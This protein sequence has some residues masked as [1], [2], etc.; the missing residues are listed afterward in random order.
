MQGKWKLAYE[1]LNELNFE[2]HCTSA[3]FIVLKGH[4]GKA[5]GVNIIFAT[6]NASVIE[7]VRTAI[8]IDLIGQKNLVHLVR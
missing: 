5:D 7:H 6:F 2:E 3:M 8:Q 4:S 1:E